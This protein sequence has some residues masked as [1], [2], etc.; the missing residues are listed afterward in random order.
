MVEVLGAR[1]PALDV[2]SL[3][4]WYGS[5]HVLQGIDLNV[6]GAPLAIVG[7]DGAG[8]TTLCQAITGLLSP[9]DR[10]RVAGSVRVDGRECVGRPPHQVAR[11][12]IAYV[13]QG[14]RVFRS[15]TVDEHLRIVPRRS[16][17]WT[18]ER[19]YQTF[20]RL[21]ERRRHRGNELSGGEQQM[22]AIGRALLT[23]P[24]ILVMDEP[25]EGLA[26]VVAWSLVATI[27]DLAASEGLGVLVVEQNLAIAAAI[28]DTVDIMVS[29]R[30][31][32]SM[33]GA[34]LLEDRDAQQRWLGVGGDPV[35]A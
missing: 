34:A 3:N 7:R 26:P 33:S 16:D 32:T 4:A 5:A 15:L 13:P 25:S 14:R 22:L 19:V 17:A 18:A 11:S 35:S 9:D 20:P 2:A 23:G 6:A 12:G 30:V 10:G 1:P 27:R 21:A 24:R 28:A 8:K 29:G 31:V